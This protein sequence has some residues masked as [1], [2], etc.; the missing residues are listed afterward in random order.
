[1]IGCTDQRTVV[2]QQA[3]NALKFGKGVHFPGEV[4]ETD[5]RAAG[6]RGSACD[7]IWNVPKS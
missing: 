1:V 2:L 7:P 3:G 4:V 5:A 6:L